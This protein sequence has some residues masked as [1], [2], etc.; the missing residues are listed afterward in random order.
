MTEPPEGERRPCRI[1][2]CVGTQLFSARSDRPT[3]SARP[4]VTRWRRLTWWPTQFSES[5]PLTPRHW[6][7][8]LLLLGEAG[9]GDRRGRRGAGLVPLRL[10]HAGGDHVQMRAIA[11]RQGFWRDAR[12]RAWLLSG[13][14]F[15]MVV[16]LAITAVSVPIAVWFKGW[17]WALDDFG[18]PVLIT[19]IATGIVAA[20]VYVFNLNRA[21]LATYG[22][23]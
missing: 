6:S 2:G 3:C 18:P 9:T 22:S 21:K 20:F 10:H 17:N 14:V 5:R 13:G 23:S 4:T 11:G 16:P 19:A 12:D 15:L 7:T 8:F 1:S